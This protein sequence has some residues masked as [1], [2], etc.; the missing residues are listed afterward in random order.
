MKNQC[1]H[2]ASYISSL[3][4]LLATIFTIG[5]T[6]TCDPLE[7]NYV[8]GNDRAQVFRLFSCETQIIRQFIVCCNNT[9]IYARVKQ[10][11][12]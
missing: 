7:P 2:L 11:V 9:V 12:Q 10:T 8:D 1:Q 3:L 5:E 6:F 4:E